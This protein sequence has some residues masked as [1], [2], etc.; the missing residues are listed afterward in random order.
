MFLIE[1]GSIVIVRNGIKEVSF[2]SLE[3]FSQ[4]YPG[5]DIL[6]KTYLDYEPDR[7]LFIDS[8][9]N[10]NVWNGAIAKYDAVINS[11]D[12]LISRKN[13]PYYLLDLAQTK[14]Y[15]KSLIKEYFW[16]KI[17]EGC[18]TTSGIRYDCDDIA[19]ANIVSAF[20]M[21]QISG[22]DSVVFIDYNNERQILTYPQLVTVGLEVAGYFTSLL[23]QKN[24]LYRYID[25]LSSIDLIKVVNW[26]T[27]LQ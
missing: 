4:Y 5:L 22:Q 13:D 19:R 27:P 12:T 25:S 23:Y 15:Q 26:E 6:S 24:N 9:L 14:I 20:L 17:E 1:K 8:S 3:E 21:L 11:I 16:D 18:L 2:V 7:Q 10:L